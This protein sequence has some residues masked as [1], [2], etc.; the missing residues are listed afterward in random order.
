MQKVHMHHMRKLHNKST[1]ITMFSSDP[2]NLHRALS[3]HCSGDG[4]FNWFA[5]LTASHSNMAERVSQH[6]TALAAGGSAPRRLRRSTCERHRSCRS[7][8]SR[9]A[10]RDCHCRRCKASKCICCMRPCDIQVSSDQC[11]VHCTCN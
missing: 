11:S 4:L 3:R 7:K 2:N 8:Q 9:R 1:K 10:R 5:S 6:A